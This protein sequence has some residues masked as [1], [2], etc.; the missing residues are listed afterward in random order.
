MELD[1]QLVQNL[2][3]MSEEAWQHGLSLEVYGKVGDR[4]GQL[5]GPE[6]RRL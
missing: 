1:D 2:K 6:S 4:Q 3:K 5:L